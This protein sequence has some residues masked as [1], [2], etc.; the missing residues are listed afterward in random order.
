MIQRLIANLFNTQGTA[1]DRA[2]SAVETRALR[3]RYRSGSVAVDALRG[4][5]LRI[6]RGEFV[7]IVGPSGCGKTS[8]LNCLAGLETDYEGEV[9][10]SVRLRALN[11]ERACGRG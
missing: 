4:I 3:K 5:D 10:L 8:L 11:G 9:L 2:A 1:P 7:A 6:A